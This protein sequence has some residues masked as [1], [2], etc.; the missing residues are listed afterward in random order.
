MPYH[1][2]THRASPNMLAHPRPTRNTTHSA[3]QTQYI[4]LHTTQITPAATTHQQHTQKGIIRRTSHVSTQRNAIHPNNKHHNACTAK[5]RITT[6]IK[7]AQPT[8]THSATAPQ[9]HNTHYPMTHRQHCRAVRSNTE[10]RESLRSGAK[11]HKHRNTDHIK[12][13]NTNARAA[14]TQRSEHASAMTYNHTSTAR[15]TP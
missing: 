11:Q 2:K 9:C 3:A 7:R 14:N 15:H 6:C 5:P 12:R 8:H 4:P 10:Q 13:N 1:S